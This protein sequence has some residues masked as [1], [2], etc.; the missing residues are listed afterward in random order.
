MTAPTV[1]APPRARAEG[2][3]KGSIILLDQCVVS[4]TNFLF[5]LL[6]GRMLVPAEYGAY[7]LAFVTL[8]AMNNFLQ[9]P[10]ILGPTVVYG[11]SLDGAEL[12]MHLSGTA[13]MQGMLSSLTALIVLGIA[14]FLSFTKP[15]LAPAFFGLS[16]VIGFEQAQE[17]LRQVLLA[18]R[19]VVSTLINDCV[20]AVLR[21]GALG[22]LILV[23][24]RG[25]G[26]IL[27]AR[28]AY[29]CAAFGAASAVFFGV[30]QIR[31][32]LANPRPGLASTLRENWRFG[33]WGL[34]GAGAV[35]VS[36]QLSPWLL[37]GLHGP[38]TLGTLGACQTMIFASN[39]LI[40]SLLSFWGPVTARDY[41]KG[42]VPALRAATRRYAFVSFLVMGSFCTILIVGA[43][44]LLHFI[45]SGRYD[46]NA[47]I[48]ALLALSTFLLSVSRPAVVAL[49]AMKRPDLSLIAQSFALVFSLVLTWPVIRYFGLPGFAILQVVNGSC[50]LLVRGGLLSRAEKEAVPGSTPAPAAPEVSRA[51]VLVVGQTPP[52][53]GGQAVM[54]EEFLAGRYERLELHHVRLQFSKDMDSIGRFSVMKVIL[55]FTTLVRIWIARLRYGTRVLYYPPS[56]PGTVPVL[57]DIVLLGCSRWMFRETVFHFHAAGVSTFAPSLPAFLRP[58]FRLAYR[59][60]AL[61][62]R[63]A[64]QNPDDGLY[65][66]A[67]RSVVVPNGIPDSR[68]S[69]EERTAAEGEE[70]VILF[71]GVLLE[72][73]GVRV[74]VEA[75][76]ILAAKGL[77]AKLQL[78][79][80]WSD[81]GFEREITGFLASRGLEHRVQVLG[82]KSG[83]TKLGFFAACDIFCFPSFFESESFG[84]VL[85]EAMEF[86]KPVVST[87]WRGIPSVVEDGRSGFLVE[88]RNAAALAERLG[89]LI[90]DPALRRSMGAAGRQI[91]EEKFTAR[92]FHENMERA[93]LASLE[94]TGG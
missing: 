16:V 59:R 68:G 14:G 31:N 18:R 67:A 52:P 70:A 62:I 88:P 19:R 93:L 38:A 29:L 91:F 77:G 9:E 21:L 61:A 15:A 92:R 24:K 84:L 80:R 82:V 75:L 12:R 74:L 72:S 85:L 69:V 40:N 13:A 37:A 54:I 43:R 28:N 94:S 83:P 55:L 25:M 73:K 53:F 65:F 30:F 36:R 1:E 49:S 66:G 60:P 64:P 26:D 22:G 6:L 76:E 17:F 41:A 39:P 11:A 10:L 44:P 5:G 87:Q 45:Y 48:L 71:T 79:G 2:A 23:Q 50:M 86:A 47:Q 35:A 42:G 81:P 78:M 51:R 56:G 20:Y 27:S 63:T 7:T 58:F 33:R 46:G 3:R 89:R 57:R 4:G 32:L 90:A 8:N 34:A